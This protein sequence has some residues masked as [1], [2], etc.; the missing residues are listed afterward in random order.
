MGAVNPKISEPSMEEILASIRR[1]IADDQELLQDA[2]RA[3]QSSEL[4]PLR[5]VLDIAESQVIPLT[6]PAS[7]EPEQESVIFGFDEDE[8]GLLSEPAVPEFPG[9]Y[10][11]EQA[12]PQ[13]VAS[14]SPVST[15]LAQEPVVREA[16]TSRETEAAVSDAFGKLGA[17]IVSSSPKTLEDLA[18]EMLRPM[19]KAWLDDNLPPLVERLVQAEIERVSRNRG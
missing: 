10:K 3:E 15:P 18:K 4:S 16:L 6:L 1:I 19:L 14:I 12:S 5:N 13:P 8:Y 11:I 9:I 7:P 17:T 2:P